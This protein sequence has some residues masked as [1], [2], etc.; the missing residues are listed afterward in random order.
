MAN[1]ADELLNEVPLATGPEGCGQP[2][3]LLIVY[4]GRHRNANGV[5]GRLWSRLRGLPTTAIEFALFIDEGGAA[6]AA[7]DPM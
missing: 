3:E 1:L 4:V 7:A 2:A 6:W 5:G